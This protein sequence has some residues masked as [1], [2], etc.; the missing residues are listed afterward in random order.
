MQLT[1]DQIQHVAKLA[2][3]DTNEAMIA[4]FTTQV[5][6]ILEYINQLNQIDTTGVA[7]T[8]HA[9]SV[10]NALR[11]D[12]LGTSFTNEQAL[13]NAPSQDDDH[14]VVPRVI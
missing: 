6:D 3:L 9:T 4:K 10:T 8:S 14:F 5:G 7:P 11:E 13:T 2:R 1:S 12:Q